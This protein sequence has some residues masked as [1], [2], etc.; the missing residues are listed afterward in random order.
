MMRKEM[1]FY[2]LLYES[3]E[4]EQKIEAGLDPSI[5]VTHW[6]WFYPASNYVYGEKVSKRTTTAV[7]KSIDKLIQHYKDNEFPADFFIKKCVHCG[8]YDHC[9]AVGGGNGYDFW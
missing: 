2:K 5:N 4:D 8:H 6:G 7:L 3:A 9:E 1:A